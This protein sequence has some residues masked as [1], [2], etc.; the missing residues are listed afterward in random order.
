MNFMFDLED[1]SN[2]GTI[3]AREFAEVCSCYGTAKEECEQAFAK[4]SKVRTTSSFILCVPAWVRLNLREKVLF[5]FSFPSAFLQ[6][7]PS[8]PFPFSMQHN[9]NRRP[10][11]FS[12]RLAG[13]TE[14]T[15][16]PGTVLNDD[17]R[18]KRK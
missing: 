3:D 14:R 5:N 11:M 4:M 10:I 16:L 15:E 7:H 1:A 9:E 12:L 13:E 18:D 6:S 8:L 17:N 2:D